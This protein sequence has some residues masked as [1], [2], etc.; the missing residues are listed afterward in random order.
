MK[1]VRITP[2]KLKGQIDVPPSKS[3][4]HRMLICASLAEGESILENMAFSDDI[5]ATINGVM[6]L[7]AQVHY[8]KEPLDYKASHMAVIG[9]RLL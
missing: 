1:C 6:A 5:P 2:S 9:N 8:L 3:I 7:G 4:S